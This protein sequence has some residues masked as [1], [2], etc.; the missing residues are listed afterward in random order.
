MKGYGNLKKAE[1]P[2]ALLLVDTD[3]KKNNSNDQFVQ[4]NQENMSI[5]QLINCNSCDAPRLAMRSA[6]WNA[7]I[8]IELLKNSI[9]NKYLKFDIISYKVANN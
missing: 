5:V 2:G 8:Y 6:E 9:I 3:K 7:P 4:S 1:P